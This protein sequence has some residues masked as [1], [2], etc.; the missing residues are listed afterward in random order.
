MTYKDIS[1]LIDQYN[2]AEKA[3]IKSNLKRIMK[4]KRF[5]SADIMK[6]GY[7]KH[8]VYAWGNIASLN[9]PLFDQAVHLAAEFDFDVK[10]LLKTS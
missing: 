6:L 1:S 7:D 2:K 10:E 5:K 8:L 3:I 4:E 9:A